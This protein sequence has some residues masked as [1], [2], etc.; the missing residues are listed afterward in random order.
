[1][2]SIRDSLART[3]QSVFGQI[4]TLLGASDIE[5]DTWDDL[6]ALLIQADVGVD[7]TLKIVERLREKVQQEGIIRA[8]SLQQALRDELRAL[9]DDPPPFKIDVKRLLTVLLVVGVNGSGKTT[10]IGKLA[11]YYRKQGRRAMLVAGDTFRAAAIDQLQVWGERARV[12][13]IAGQP[14]GD[15]GA[16]LYDAIQSSRA[17]NVD[18]LIVDTAGRLHTQ[19]NLMAELKKIH[20]VAQKNVH[21]A[22][23][24]T[25]LVLDASTGQNA[26]SQARH[27]QEAVNV[28]G[29]ALAKLDGSAKGGMV[30]AIR[31]ALG[32]PVRMVGTGEGIEDLAVFD[33]DQFI[34]GL[35]A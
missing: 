16:V 32:L 4:A 9:F 18:L 19:Y 5:D 1:L 6:E 2:A 24:E 7:A 14:G 22:P 27:F 26:L 8:T 10:T 12:P 17:R 11:Y 20:G 31:E 13:V 25:L 23:H 35:F 33:P 34:E 29:V 15:P 3:R 21:A 30:L 28:T